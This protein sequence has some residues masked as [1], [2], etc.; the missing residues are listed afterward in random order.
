MDIVQTLRTEYNKVL[1]R[2]DKAT[3]FLESP[4]RTPEEVDQWL[5]EYESILKQR[6]ELCYKIWQI[7]GI[8]PAVE[9]FE[10]GFI[11]IGDTVR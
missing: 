1:A 4:K 7:S 6:Q 9:E 8:K 5:P 3:K 11:F 2:W 10:G